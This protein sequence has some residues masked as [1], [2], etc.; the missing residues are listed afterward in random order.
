MGQL[1]PQKVIDLFTGQALASGT[2]VN[3]FFSRLVGDHYLRWFNDNVADRGPW[4]TV[5][6]VDTMD[7]LTRFDHFWGHIDVLF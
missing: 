3:A 6:L 2:N 1:I 5:R 7:N 4:R